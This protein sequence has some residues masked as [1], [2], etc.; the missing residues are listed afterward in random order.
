MPMNTTLVGLSAGV[1]QHDLPH[2]AGDLERRRGCA[3]SPSGRSRRRR[4]RARSRPGTRCRACGGSRDGIS[5]DSIA[6]PSASRQRILPGAVGRL[7]D[8][9]RAR[10][11]AAGSARSS[12]ARSARGQLGGVGP[13]ADRRH[14]EP[15]QDLVRPG[16]A[17]GPRSATQ[18][19]SASRAAAGVRSSRMG[20]GDGSRTPERCMARNDNLRD[21]PEPRG[22]ARGRLT[23]RRISH[24]PPSDGGYVCPMLRQVRV[25]LLTELLT[26][27]RV[28]VPLAARD[29][30]G[31]HRRAGAPSGRPRRRRLRRGARR[32]SKSASR[33]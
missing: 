6:S 30:R 26:P 15:P 2:L 4:T 19:A 7:L 8:H 33:C 3:G 5:T 16:S 23:A 14:P 1:A 21:S 11:G 32:R 10:A 12:S 28:V 17:A 29:K 24:C 22:K 20:G 31:G 18:A 25:V 9:V 27:D 13:A